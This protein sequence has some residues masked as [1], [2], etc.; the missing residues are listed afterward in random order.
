MVSNAI[1]KTYKL[2]RCKGDSHSSRAVM[3]N[4]LYVY[5]SVN[6]LDQIHKNPG[7]SFIEDNELNWVKLACKIVCVGLY[8]YECAALK[9]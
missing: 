9:G 6:T 8:I 2:A 1:F 4:T 7:F 3:K 5:E